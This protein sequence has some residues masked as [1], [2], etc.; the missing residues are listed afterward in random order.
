MGKQISKE[1][2]DRFIAAWDEAVDG[3]FNHDITVPHYQK[4]IDEL[5]D[6]QEPLGIVFMYPGLVA[7]GL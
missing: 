4:L 1:E 7:E 3:R 2:R 5:G 6:A